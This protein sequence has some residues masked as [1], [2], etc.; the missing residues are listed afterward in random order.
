V[1]EQCAILTARQATT[2]TG[3]IMRVGVAVKHSIA[4]YLKTLQQAG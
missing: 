1:L 2:A 4:V 3:V